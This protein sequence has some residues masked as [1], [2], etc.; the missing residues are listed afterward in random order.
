VS[1]VRNS[2]SRGQVLLE[3][4]VVLHCKPYRETSLFVDV[5]TEHHGRLRLVAKGA[6]K[7]K[8]P[9]SQVLR[10]FN[11]VEV[12]W[13][14]RGDLPSMTSAES[15]GPLWSL[16]G[17]ALYS[18]FYLTELLFNFL[19]AN[20]PQ[21]E[22]YHLYCETLKSLAEEVGIQESLRYFELSLLDEVGYGLN[23]FEDSNG[24]PIEPT[25]YYHYVPERGAVLLDAPAPDAVSGH[26]LVAMA[27][28]TLE[29]SIELKE[30]R[31]MMRFIIGHH[32]NGRP[33]KSR[34]LF[35]PFTSEK[36]HEL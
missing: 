34:E 18:G 16:K 15:K 24:Y 2:D 31:A 17:A 3:P 28:R 1:L 21:P 10:P 26:T 6:R 30:S 33:L 29:G 36:R 35:K 22:I 13:I 23:L 11:R 27:S 4:S 25:R 9:W 7:G 12:S 32:L 14:G 19:P 20:D 5:L 8:S